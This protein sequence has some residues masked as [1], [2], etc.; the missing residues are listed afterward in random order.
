MQDKKKMPTV[1][2]SCGENAVEQSLASFQVCTCPSCG[3]QYPPVTTSAKDHY[4]MVIQCIAL[5]LVLLAMGNMD[6]SA[7]A[8]VAVDDEERR[9]LR[10]ELVRTLRANVAANELHFL[11]A[12][13]KKRKRGSPD[14]DAKAYEVIACRNDR[15]VAKLN[16]DPAYVAKSP[17]V[18]KPLGAFTGVVDGQSVLLVFAL[19]ANS[20]LG[21]LHP[22]AEKSF[23]AQH[24]WL[25]LIVGA[26]QLSMYA[27][28]NKITLSFF[29]AHLQ[30]T[31]N[32]L[33]T[34]TH[35]NIVLLFLQGR[36]R[37]AE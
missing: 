29:Y 6:G 31:Y 3:W 26:E 21:Q 22:K 23:A 35:E 19:G 15:M 24:F 17:E 10:E 8:P 30:H 9:R 5:G 27:P 33:T 34:H 1:C 28:L 20:H 37:D 7:F 2:Q 25:P 36:A 32:T 4:R 16:D 18:W 13:I 12:P 11:Q 14:P